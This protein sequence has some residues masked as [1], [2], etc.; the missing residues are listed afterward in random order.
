MELQWLRD[1]VNELEKHLVHFHQLQHQLEDN[2]QRLLRRLTDPA[3]QSERMEQFSVHV[4][5]HQ[6]SVEAIRAL[7]QKALA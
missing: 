5:R 3:L 7:Y 1:H 4:D 2:Y 6:Q